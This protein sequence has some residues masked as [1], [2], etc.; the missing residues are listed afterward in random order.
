MAPQSVGCVLNCLFW[1]HLHSCRG[2]K[3]IRNPYF[4]LRN[5]WCKYEFKFG[6]FCKAWGFV[7]KPRIWERDRIISNKAQKSLHVVEIQRNPIWRTTQYM[8]K[9]E[10]KY[11]HWNMYKIQ[12]NTIW[13]KY[14]HKMI[15]VST[16]WPLWPL[17]KRQKSIERSI[18]LI[19]I[20]N[21]QI[22]KEILKEIVEQSDYCHHIIYYLTL[23]TLSTLRETEEGDLSDGLLCC[24]KEHNVGH[25]I[26]H[27]NCHHHHHFWQAHILIFWGIKRVRWK[28]LPFRVGSK[29]WV[30]F[31]LTRYHINWGIRNTSKRPQAAQRSSS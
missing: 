3:R 31:S 5:I 13:N 28:I 8:D 10:T 9:I 30:G 24:K 4:P 15:I 22:L 16:F 11:F 18:A 14:W 1:G 27:H 17:S 29:W 7:R 21:Q 2:K 20:F 23:T 19:Q 12:D 26:C 25:D 6:L